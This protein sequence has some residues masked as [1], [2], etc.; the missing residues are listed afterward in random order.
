MPASVLVCWVGCRL[1]GSRR[2]TAGPEEI[3]KH[4]FVRILKFE[5]MP[6]PFP[7]RLAVFWFML[8]A[9]GQA[10]LAP[11]R[12]YGLVRLTLCRLARILGIAAAYSELSLKTEQKKS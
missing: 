4:L 12:G 2:R 9:Q 6:P 3:A 8:Q 5:K 7:D 1:G 10:T 11:L